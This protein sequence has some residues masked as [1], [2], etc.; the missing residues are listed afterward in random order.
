MAKENNLAIIQ[1]IG[2]GSSK[3]YLVI[4]PIGI[5]KAHPKWFKRL[6]FVST[7]VVSFQRQPPHTLHWRIADSQ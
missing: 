4:I 2:C 1:L 3:M 6:L 7:W 5:G